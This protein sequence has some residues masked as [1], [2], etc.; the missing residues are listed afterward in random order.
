M[1]PTRYASCGEAQGR[2]QTANGDLAQSPSIGNDLS[3]WLTA[4]PKGRFLSITLSLQIGAPELPALGQQRHG[5]HQVLECN[6]PDQALFVDYRDE[7]EVAG[8]QFAEGGG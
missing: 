7:T 3:K 4:S 5:V 1:R 8:G 6:D 2:K